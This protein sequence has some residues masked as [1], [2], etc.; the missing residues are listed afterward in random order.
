MLAI[1]ERERE[2]ERERG[3]VGKIWKKLGELN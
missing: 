1:R 3:E 2:R